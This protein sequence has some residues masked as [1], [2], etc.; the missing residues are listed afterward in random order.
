MNEDSVRQL[1]L[2][3][4]NYLSQTG[5][6]SEAVRFAQSRG[7]LDSDGRATEEGRHLCEALASQLETRSTFRNLPM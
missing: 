2:A 5:S 4:E 6:G 3:F 7:W 1:I